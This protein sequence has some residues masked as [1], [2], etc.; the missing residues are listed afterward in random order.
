MPPGAGLS[1]CYAGL[2]GGLDPEQPVYG[3]QD[4]GLIEPGDPDSPPADPGTLGALETPASL[5][6]LAEYYV[7][8]IT[9]LRPDGPCRLLGWS[10]G[11]HLAHEVAVRL[12]ERGR[13]VD[14]LVVLDSYPAELPLG[15]GNGNENG[16]G[17]GGA[18]SGEP[19]TVLAD[20]FGD[21][22][23]DPGAPDAL[24]RALRFV[25]AEL[26][27]GPFGEADDA[28]AAR[29]LE[30]YFL[31]TRALL[32]FRHRRYEGD[33]MFFR[34]ADWTVDPDR[35]DVSRWTPNVSG[36]IAV[37]ELAAKHE[38]IGRPDILAEAGKVIAGIDSTR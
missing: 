7:E 13:Q 3:L 17:D 38:E 10:A 14:R 8:V 22:L 9:G 34:A 25:R 24:E 36:E 31:S 11:G 2:L 30:T 5:G 37:H 21:A 6:E 29:V 4:P 27:E 19:E 16:D 35:R 32:G 23:P 26:A 12:Q 1:W 15:N 20:V 28:T 18:G 33:L